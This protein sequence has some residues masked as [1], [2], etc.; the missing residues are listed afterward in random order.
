MPALQDE[1]DRIGDALR[2]KPPHPRR[3]ELYAAQQALAW[4][5]DPASA[6]RPLAVFTGTLS[7]REGYPGCLR[8]PQSSDT[9]S[10]RD[11][12][13]PRPQQCGRPA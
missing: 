3:A 4:A 12:A 2:A 7:D 1:L 10:Q 13:P 5:L 9:G 11:S 6:A 8:P